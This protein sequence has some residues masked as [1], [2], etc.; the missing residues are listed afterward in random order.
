[1]KD[2]IPENINTLVHMTCLACEHQD[3]IV[4]TQGQMLFQFVMTHIMKHKLALR[5]QFEILYVKCALKPIINRIK[6]LN[7]AKL[8]DNNAKDAAQQSTEPAKVEE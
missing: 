1:M 8:K 2:F 3:L 7:E 6:T 4:K 5:E